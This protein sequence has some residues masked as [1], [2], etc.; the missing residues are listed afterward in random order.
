MNGVHD[1]VVVG[2]GFAGLAAARLL[3]AHGKSIVVLEASDRAGG[4]VWARS[5]AQHNVELDWGAEWVIPHLHPRVMAEAARLG[6]SADTGETHA[7][8]CWQIGTS[9]LFGSYQDMKRNRPRFAAALSAIEDEARLRPA[10]VNSEGNLRDYF[11]RH[12]GT[13][14]DVALLEC[15]VFPLTG[16]EPQ[17]T[18]ILMLWDEISAHCG[19]ID[20]TLDGDTHR[21]LKG[22]GSIGPAMAAEIDD[23]LVRDAVVH[24]VFDRG[25]SVEVCAGDTTYHANHCIMAVPLR[26]L[27]NLSF[28]PE[29]PASHRHTAQHSNAGRVAKVWAHA[30][31]A[32]VP[33]TVLHHT[34]PLRY[35][36]ARAASAGEW[37]VCGQYLSQ[38]DAPVV[39][40]DV[41]SLFHE[42]W[43][44]IDVA[45]IEI[46][47]WPN[48]PLA[49]G[50]WHTG[51]A[52]F[53]GA[54]EVFRQPHG[55]IHFAGG[56]I[57]PLWAGWM[58]G[59]LLSGE[60]VAQIVAARL[61]S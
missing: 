34:S 8:T 12:A 1:V 15:A 33:D 18:A 24:Q 26:T 16:S 28:T 32:T 38:D 22:V 31:Y 35:A 39:M 48:L 50:S 54:V 30:R 36:Y 17:D 47:D 51:R 37:Y 61:G 60:E 7:R 5:L 27:E 14:D 52:G 6:L 11:L 44:G 20:E 45:A 57:A 40:S 9:T 10:S 56:D 2:A 59:A 13:A 58:E 21:F 29:L 46:S 43:P 23:C 4:R 41:K 3:W 49:R 25:D 19:S 53:A 42:T 55:N